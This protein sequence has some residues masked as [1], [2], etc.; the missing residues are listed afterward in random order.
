MKTKDMMI[1]AI[2]LTVA[3]MLPAAACSAQTCPD[4]ATTIDQAV[5]K[6][7]SALRGNDATAFMS[8]IGADGLTLGSE[9]M[10]M[11]RDELGG[12]LKARNGVYCDLFT[13][14][15]KAGRLKQLITKGPT[16]TRMNK[17]RNG[18]VF[19]IVT[20]NRGHATDEVELHFAFVN[21]RWELMAIGT[22]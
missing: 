7:Q 6:A 5:N 12:E 18:N 1:R 16:S 20:I 19:A 8:L 3:L 13:C 15:G 21:C 17:A 9:G 14:G 10:A 11:G 22:L 2:A 4:P